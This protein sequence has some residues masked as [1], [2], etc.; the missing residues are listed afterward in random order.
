MRIWPTSTAAA[1][2]FVMLCRDRWGGLEQ[3]GFGI[4]FLEAAACG[5]PQVAGASG[6]AADAVVDGETG[7]VLADPRD[8]VAAAVAIGGLLDDGGLRRRMGEES[9]RRAE[10]G[11]SW[12][13]LAGQLGDALARWE[14]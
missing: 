6:G 14:P 4:V 2:V 11:F 10:R 1:D 13:A 12:D 9:R 3:E 8:P 7:Y 5:V